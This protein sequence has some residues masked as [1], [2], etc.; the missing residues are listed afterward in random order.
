VKRKSKTSSS[1]KD[2]PGK[3]KLSTVDQ[4]KMLPLE[5]VSISSNEIPAEVAMNAAPNNFS[6]RREVTL[7]TFSLLFL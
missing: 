2:K 4:C 6:S 1:R 7:Y 3:Q 5:S